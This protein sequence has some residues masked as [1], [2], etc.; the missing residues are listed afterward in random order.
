[1][2]FIYHTLY[3]K[4]NYFLIEIKTITQLGYVPPIIIPEKIKLTGF[5]LGLYF[6]C[7]FTDLLKPSGNLTIV[8]S[9][10]YVTIF[11]GNTGNF[12]RYKLLDKEGETEVVGPLYS[13][14]AY[15]KISVSNIGGDWGSNCFFC[16][17]NNI[18]KRFAQ[19]TRNDALI[20][21]DYVTIIGYPY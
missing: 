3:N 21:K 19:I 15:T 8:G 5:N 4:L 14:K 18:L 10:Q 17:E 16:L 13:Y 6:Y 1:M 2:L 12:Y 9:T 11:I 7:P 20:C